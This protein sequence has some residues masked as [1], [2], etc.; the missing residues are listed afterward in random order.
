MGLRKVTPRPTKVCAHCGKVFEFPKRRAYY[1]WKVRTYCTVTC[2]RDARRGKVFGD[3]G[4]EF[5]PAEA[6]PCRICGADTRY[7]GAPSV[8]GR[9]VCDNPECRQ[10]SRAIRDERNRATNARK[11]AMGIRSCWW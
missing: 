4:Q 11:R 5:L 10:R 8:A 6:V 7:R 3:T 2:Q 9:V 1:E